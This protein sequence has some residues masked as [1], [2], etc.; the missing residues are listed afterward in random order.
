[1]ADPVLETLHTIHVG[2]AVLAH[3]PPAADGSLPRPRRPDWPA[4]DYIVGNPPFI[5]GKDILGRLGEADATARGKAHPKGNKSAEY[6]MYWW[7][8]AAER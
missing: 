5:C 2:D 1:I 7:D 8:R 4:A 3:D 6:V